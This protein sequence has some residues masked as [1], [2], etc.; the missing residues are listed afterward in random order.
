M[1]QVRK[2]EAYETV[3]FNLGTDEVSDVVEVNAGDV[4]RVATAGN[5]NAPVI[6][7]VDENGDF[8]K[9]LVEYSGNDNKIYLKSFQEHCYIRFNTYQDARRKIYKRS[10]VGRFIA[11]G[12]S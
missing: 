2:E 3:A 1:G 5:S 4:F 6:A 8:I 9:V 10:S 7:E 12:K 11:Y